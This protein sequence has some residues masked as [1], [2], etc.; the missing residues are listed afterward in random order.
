VNVEAVRQEIRSSIR[1]A[2]GQRR[3]AQ[4]GKDIRRTGR[5]AMR[6]QTDEERDILA[7]SPAVADGYPQAPPPTP[8][9]RTRTAYWSR[10]PSTSG[11][12]TTHDTPLLFDWLTGSRPREGPPE[13]RAL[14]TASPPGPTIAGC[15]RGE[16][17][18]R[19]LGATRAEAAA[20]F[21]LAFLVVF[22]DFGGGVG[23]SK[24]RQRHPQAVAAG[25]S[26]E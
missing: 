7:L 11:E 15:D 19:D 5:D 16:K 18:L 10:N 22:F 12:A 23:S 8:S 25:L 13:S 26:S 2:D 4:Y 20:F 21:F 1:R 24:R 14:R 6:R 9:S 3:R 17:R